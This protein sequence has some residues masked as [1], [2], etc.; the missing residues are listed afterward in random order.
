MHEENTETPLRLC[1]EDARVFALKRLE[2]AIQSTNCA[3][4]EKVHLL[5]ITCPLMDGLSEAFEYLG[6]GTDFAE[7]RVFYIDRLD[8]SDK[9]L[10]PVFEI[11]FYAPDGHLYSLQTYW[12]DGEYACDDPLDT[13]AISFPS[14]NKNV[15]FVD[16]LRKTLEAWRHDIYRLTSQDLVKASFRVHPCWNGVEKT[17]AGS[18]SVS[19]TST[20]GRSPKRRGRRSDPEE[21][22]LAEWIVERRRQDASLSYEQIAETKG[23]SLSRFLRM[24]R[25]DPEGSTYPTE[26]LVAEAKRLYDLGRKAP[27]SRKSESQ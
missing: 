6:F 7:H 8:A 13:N 21:R 19:D 5:P 9:R 3:F 23:E 22:K 26:E 1:F 12:C 2:D 15:K 17:L 20:K 4:G 24:R 11:G 10:D 16:S 25:R 27:K 14:F 18:R